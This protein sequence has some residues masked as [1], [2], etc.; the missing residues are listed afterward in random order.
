M[1]DLKQQLQLL[2]KK[3]KEEK[4]FDKFGVFF[5]PLTILYICLVKSV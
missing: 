1:K 3:I 2:F 4:A 5:L